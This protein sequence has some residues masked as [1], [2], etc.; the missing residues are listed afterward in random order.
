MLALSL[1]K[2]CNLS[3]AYMLTLKDTYCTD[4]MENVYNFSSSGNTTLATLSVLFCIN[5]TEITN[6]SVWAD[7]ITILHNHPVVN[8]DQIVRVPATCTPGAQQY[9]K[10]RM[11]FNISFPAQPSRKRGRA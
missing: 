3:S 2:C 5:A 6:G 9:P 1:S 7:C 10:N 11:H 4:S 8:T